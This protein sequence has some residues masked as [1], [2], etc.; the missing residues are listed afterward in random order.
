MASYNR[1][2]GNTAY[3]SGSNLLKYGSSG[4]QV[5]TL[6]QL[7]NAAGNYGLDEDGNFGPKTLEAVKKYQQQNGLTVDGIVGTN[8]WGALN[9]GTTG[10]SGSSSGS[11]S[12]APA[13]PQAP[14][15]DYTPS[16]TVAQAEALLQQQLANK[17]G[18]YQSSWQE[19]LNE[20][21]QQILNREKFS[22]DLNGDALYQQY[23]DQYTTQGKLASMDVMGQAA[24]MTGGYGNSY[25]QAAGQQAYQGYLQQL[26]DKVPELYQ[27]AL[28]QYNQ[29][30]QDLYNQAS[31]MA[32]MEDQDYGRYRDQLSDYYTDLN[33]LTENARY[34]SETEYQKALDDFQIK[35][36]AYRDDVA[37]KQW[38][39]TF[40]EGVRQYNQNYALQQESLALQRSSLGGGTGGTGGGGSAVYSAPDGW[41]KQQIRQFQ[42]KYGL[43]ED[44]VW[45][46][47][48][49]TRYAQENSGAVGNTG[50]SAPVI[51]DSIYDRASEFTNNVELGQWLD[52]LEQ[53]GSI[54][55]QQ[56]DQLYAQ[57][58]QPDILDLQDRTWVKVSG[59]GI[60][61]GGGIDENAKVKDQYGNQY[62]MKRL[63]K[64]LQENGV[65][66]PTAYRFVMQTQRNLGLG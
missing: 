59:G 28:N 3:S 24:A 38:Q 6:Q 37:D 15:F 9:K 35:Y 41:T 1:E 26:N 63:Y 5:K 13:E 64:E 23:K 47:E 30:G 19:Q 4:S 17:P 10:S 16:D 49:A 58:K 39:A 56:S 11:T 20:T 55:S 34:M 31:L 42:H 61:W 62:T 54:T 53:A 8:T 29:E 14:T 27:L 65:D 57:Y 25:A 43:E 22:Y 51:S 2:S 48:E 36:G 21:L 18:E 45:G 33:Y 60:N 46:K 40:D 12:T 52:G 44:G 7:L 50:G 66:E 32:Q